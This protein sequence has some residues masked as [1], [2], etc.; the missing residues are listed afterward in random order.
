[1]AISISKKNQNRSVILECIFRNAPI[2]R[3]EISDLTKI[4]PATV[5]ANITELI[6]EGIVY[7]TGDTSGDNNSSGRKRILIDI[8][9]DKAFSIGVE[10]T[11]R[12]LIVCLT[13][14]KGTIIGSNT[15]PFE[16]LSLNLITEEII[17]EINKILDTSKINLES[18]IGIGI[19]VPG[20]MNK[21]NTKLI[22]N[23]KIWGS[24]NPSII[25]K[26]FPF[27]VVIENNVHCMTLGQ[28]LFDAKNTPSNFIY[29]HVSYGMFCSHITNG[30]IYYKDNFMLGEIGHTIVDI[31]GPHCECG[32]HGCLQTY[33]SESWLVKNA[34][35]LFENSSKT[36]LKS[37]VDKSSEIKIDHILTAYSMGDPFISNY[38]SNAIKYLGVSISNL[39]IILG[40]QKIYLHGVLFDNDLFKKEILDFINQQLLF[41]DTEYN[42]N[43]EI[44]K[45]SSTDGA[46]GASALSIF[47]FFVNEYPFVDL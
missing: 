18:I 23:N 22:T 24:F 45:L 15:I 25:R 12:A 7:E 36:Y 19:A 32:K 26:E 40:T 8:V 44:L 34:R 41:V 3:I 47:N 1:M 5:T 17:S 2:S 31:S 10:F 9:A 28:Y 29:F 43:I 21:T 16:N 4:T 39:S 11:Q 13:D 20:H 6:N 30:R 42:C 37:L 33:A 35:T 46:V 14:L 27:P 38:I